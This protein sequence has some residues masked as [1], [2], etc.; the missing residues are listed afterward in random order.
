MGSIGE[1]VVSEVL[2]FVSRIELPTCHFVDWRLLYL[3][4]GTYSVPGP[5]VNTE[6]VSRGIGATLH[7]RNQKMAQTR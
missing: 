2:V 5:R 6:V 1:V 7:H 4:L 3:G